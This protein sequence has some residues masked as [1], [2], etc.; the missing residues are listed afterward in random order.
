MATEYK[1]VRTAVNIEQSIGRSFRDEMRN[2]LKTN[3]D[4]KIEHIVVHKPYHVTVIYSTLI[5][6]ID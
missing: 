5:K 6:V 1:K 3:P 2:F 4:A